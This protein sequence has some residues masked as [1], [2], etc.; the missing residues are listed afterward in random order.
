MLKTTP[1]TAIIYGIS[2]GTMLLSASPNFAATSK[3]KSVDAAFGEGH[4]FHGN[5]STETAEGEKQLLSGKYDDASSSFRKAL[6]KN[7]KDIS[8]LDGL[9][10]ALGLQFK[11]D[12][13]D[14]Q[15]DKAIKLNAKDPLA[16]V[17]KA[18]IKLNRLQSS[19]MTIIKQRSSYLSAAESECQTALS[20]DP[21]MPEALTVLGM[22]KK[23]QGLLN[24]AI[25]DYTKALTTDPKF[26]VAYTRRGLAYLDQGNYVSAE[27]DLKQAI[28]LR[29]ANAAAHYGLGRAY[30]GEGRIDDALKELNTALSLNRNSAPIH[31]ALGDA[32]N[33]Q[34]NTVAALS[35]YQKAIAIKSENTDA[36][37]RIA[38]IYE[39]RGDLEMALADLRS[40]LVLN[41]SNESLHKRI[42][43]TNLRLEK[44]DNAIKEYT[45]ALDITP[46]D[47][48]AVKGL[49][50]AYLLK[51]QKDASGAFFVSN[52]YEEAERY[53]QRAIQLNPNDLELRLA[54][55]KFQAMSGKT[56]D[57]STI[58]TPHNDA[59]RV[60]YAEA[61]LAQ[62]KYDEA[63]Q[64]MQTVINNQ[65]DPKQLFALADLSLMIHDLT[66][67][68]IAY[69]KADS[70]PNCDERA[71]R[72][73]NAVAKVRADSQKSLNLANDLSK[74]KQLASSIDNY[75]QAAYL[76]P[77]L[78][79]AHYGLA[80]AL[81]K[82]YAKDPAH[83]REAAAQYKAYVALTPNL[84]DKDKEKIQKT[85]EKCIEKAYDIE[86]KTS[87]G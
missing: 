18:F 35:E 49:T 47:A 54:E 56:V 81:K 21:G 28:S 37:I 85:A 75:R 3:G 12:G 69:Q 11:L 8:A 80:E 30:L 25:S 58:G 27:Q 76:N 2:I 42:A 70:F 72:G 38:D 51:S 87:N 57:L 68:T 19:N 63:A 66:S 15:F 71:K 20:Q 7:S 64:Q 9:G 65:T 48:S 46:G 79:D 4:I 44:F 61:L 32:Y 43:D 59:E 62:L 6:N 83:L 86:K 45:A 78:A 40:G 84:P 13:A 39:D 60:A 55:A 1:R 24:E 67:A 82:Y 73:L 50:R 36:Y 5:V 26:A 22:I 29:S 23:E 17:G 77:R 41:P 74:R 16:H 14:Q 33:K 10:F 31:I 34:G 52:N 53:I